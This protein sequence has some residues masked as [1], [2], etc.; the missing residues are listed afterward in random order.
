MVGDY[1]G[2]SPTAVRIGMRNNLLPIGL[3]IHIEEKD[4]RFCESRSYHIVAQRLI[5]YNHGSISEFQI[6]TYSLMK[7]IRGNRF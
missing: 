2:N 5:A 6:A 7:L 4:C 3:A 1:L